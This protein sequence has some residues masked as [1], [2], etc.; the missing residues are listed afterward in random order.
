MMKKLLSL[1]IVCLPPLLCAQVQP[2]TDATPQIFLNK[3]INCN[4]NTCQNVPVGST[5][6]CGSISCQELLASAQIVVMSTLSLP[7]L[8]SNSATTNDTALAALRT[9]LIASPTTVWRLVFDKCPGTYQYTNN[10]WLWGVQNVILDAWGCTFE[11][12]YS[13]SSDANGIPF[14]VGDFFGTSGYGGS[15][16]T[17]GDGYLI[18]TVSAGSFTVTTSTAGNAANFSTGNQ[19][20]VYGYDQQGA[21]YPPNMRYFDFATVVSANASTGVV[22]LAAPLAHYYDSRWWDTSNYAG[23]GENYGAPRVINLQRTDYSIPQLIWIIGA[24]FNVDPNLTAAN[25]LQLTGQLVIYDHVTGGPGLTV[26]TGQNRFNYISFG[27]FSPT[28][29]AVQP[30][31]IVERE[32]ISDTTISA[33]NSQAL[34]DCVGCVSLYLARDTFYGAITGSPRNFIIDG[35]DVIPYTSYCCSALGSGT[36]WPTWNMSIKDAHLYNTGG[37]LNGFE[38]HASP[39]LSFTAG[40]GS[41]SG[42]ISLTFAQLTANAID[43]GIT[44]TDATTPC[45]AVITQI[46]ESGSD[47]IID[48]PGCTFTSGDT[49]DFYAVVNLSDQGGNYIL[50]NGNS[51]V[52]FYR[53][54][55]PTLPL[56]LDNNPTFTQGLTIGSGYN[57][58]FSGCT[59]NYITGI[60]TGFSFEVCGSQLMYTSSG[61]SLI[62]N[63]QIYLNDLDSSNFQLLYSHTAPTISTGFGTGAS[64]VSNSGTGSF[65]I[66]VGTGGTADGG[67]IGLPT[68]SHGWAGNCSDNTNSAS[69]VEGLASATNSVT[70]TNYGRTTGTA[71]AWAPSDILE[72]SLWAN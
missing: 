30:D 57:L 55:Y 36:A 53:A 37:L 15:G 50:A 42:V 66:N 14:N 25:Y 64:I 65:S 2:S 48:A 11:N 44:L 62:M 72:C 22:T 58:N 1:L 16:T 19:V 21:G 63:H 51:I 49:I 31:K 38:Q 60:S 18:N 6:N 41:G 46:Y 52:P 47:L 71:T 3:T 70:I 24:T 34:A 32:V 69:S 54:P 7:V 45:S 35:I 59:N 56:A 26:F 67:V 43:Y 9:T 4:N 10:Q 23:T 39:G 61:P 17:F 33:G 20:L 27:N 8:P 5:V 29:E 40:A 12:V 13:G 28:N 68:A